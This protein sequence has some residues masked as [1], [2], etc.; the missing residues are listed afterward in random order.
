MNDAS[1]ANRHAV[2]RQFDE[3]MVY[4]LVSVMPD[5]PLSEAE[6]PMAH[7]RRLLSFWSLPRNMVEEESD[8]S[9]FWLEH[10]LTVG[11]DPTLT[12]QAKARLTSATR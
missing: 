2:A 5:Y 12:A 6:Q 8:E 9:M 4:A 3:G 7:A 10:L 1:Y 11:L